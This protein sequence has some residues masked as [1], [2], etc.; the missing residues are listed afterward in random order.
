MSKMSEL[1]VFVQ[2][3]AA[4]A[5]SSLQTWIEDGE[6]CSDLVAWIVTEVVAMAR[7]EGVPPEDMAFVVGQA[8]SLALQQLDEEAHTFSLEDVD[9]TAMTMQ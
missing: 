5:A 8:S 1:D 4:S 7:L 2:T 3:I 9:H 6:P